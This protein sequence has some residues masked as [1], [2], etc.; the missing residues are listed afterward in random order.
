MYVG[1][2]NHIDVTS[3]QFADFIENGNLYI[4]KTAFIEHILQ[5]RNRVLL[6]TRPRR[7][8]KSLNMN[9]LAAF[10]DCKRDTAQLFSGLYIEGSEKFGE[11][12]KYPVIYLSFKDYR[13]DSFKKLLRWDIIK[14]M[15]KYL[16][17]EQYG[18][19]LT[20]YINDKNDYEP[21]ILKE[22]TEVLSDIYGVKPY[23][24]IDEY[25]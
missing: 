9:T 15:K 18:S 17:P 5:D 16:S 4:D 7:M 2:K 22:L 19:I 11:I 3:S 21:K 12:N 14:T 25:D 8:G 6:F 23:I 10:L 24:L 20:D 1:N 13:I